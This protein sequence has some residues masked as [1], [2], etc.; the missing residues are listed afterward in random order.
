MM[1]LAIEKDV[2]LTAGVTCILISYVGR[3]YS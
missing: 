1:F 3:M 2:Q